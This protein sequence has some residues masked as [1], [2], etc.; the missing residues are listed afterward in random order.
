MAAQPVIAEISS[1]KMKADKIA[2]FRNLRALAWSGKTLYASSGYTVLAAEPEHSF[3]WREVGSFHPAHWRRLTS[4]NRLSSRLV[5]DGFHALAV[6]PYGN[7]IAAVPGAI[8]TLNAGDKKFRVTH[9]I[10]RGTRP[11]HITA[12]PD[13]RVL[14][15]EYF[16]NQARDAVHIYASD[17]G[18]ASWHVTYTFPAHSVRHI[19]N[20]VYD[21]WV[22]CYWILTGD[23][24]PECRIIRASPD[25]TTMQ[26]ILAGDQQ[27]RAVSAIVNEDGLYFASDT[28]LEQNYISH[29]D[30]DGKLRRLSTIT[31]SSIYA[32]R[33]RSGMFFS[34]MVEPSEA[35]ESTDVHLYSS[36]SGA[37]WNVLAS[38]RKDRWSMK[39]FQYGNVFLP[40]GDNQTEL[41][42]ATTIA[43]RGADLQTTVWR[44]AND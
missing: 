28:P 6:P 23:C 20:I 32:C 44:T 10:T 9:R 17:D 26:E 39:F 29:L 7:L 35:N 40:D 22:N 38:W 41:L 15:G 3:N 13:G 27:A 43:V 18:G 21:R 19:H 33:N 16:D 4:R 25:F 34:T 2:T 36:E 8:V 12:V 30:R 42:A 37:E 14:W 1:P 5:R 11:L 24:G 31:S